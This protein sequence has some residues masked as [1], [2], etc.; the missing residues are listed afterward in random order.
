M[1]Q[2]MDADADVIVV[3]AGSAGATLA[4][5]LAG[6]H[7]TR[8]LLIELG[9]DRKSP[10]MHVPIGVAKL[11]VGRHRSVHHY[12]TVSQ[13]GLTDR[14]VLWPRGETVGGSGR[15]NGMVWV[16]GDPAEFDAWEHAGNTGWGSGT[17]A[18]LFREIEKTDTGDDGIRGRQGPIRVT[19]YTPQ[20]PL[21]HA[22]LHACESV[23]I[24]RT[25]DYNGSSYLGAG[26]LQ[27]NTA[28]GRRHDPAT[29]LLDAARRLPNLRILASRRVSH[30]VF[31]GRNAV[32]VALAGMPEQVLRA[33]CVVLAAGAIGTPVLLQRSGIGDAPRLQAL[34]IQPVHHLPG[35]GRNLQ[36]HLHVRMNF[37]SRGVTTLNDIAHSPIAFAAAVARYA[38]RRDGLLACATCTAHALSATSDDPRADVKIQLHHLTSSDSRAAERIVL[39]R[40]S[41]FSLGVFQLRPASRGSLHILSRDAGADPHIDPRYLDDRNDEATI[42]RGL[43][44]ARRIA[45][46]PSM[47]RFVV[48]EIRP[49]PAVKGID[50]LLTHARESGSTSYHPV[51]T[52]RMGS[53]NAAVVDP[54]LRVHGVSGLRVADASVMPTLPSANPHAA[55]I[56]IGWRAAELL[57]IRD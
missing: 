19:E 48:D 43:A 57:Q 54:T 2:A 37:R 12:P 14:A 53:D 56:A 28:H 4:A 10:W 34:G 45:N 16:R 1:T 39:D 52:C 9:A 26:M 5:R 22:F 23:G 18:R 51:G 55:V 47:Q 20:D 40:A 29:A 50:A 6:N 8:V 13:S 7:S 44:L 15:I 42:V 25:D 3:G 31:E 21:S 49:G 33:P 35:V 41:G 32:G 11:L 27:H 46:A 17:F 38:L 36:D 30:V 24:A